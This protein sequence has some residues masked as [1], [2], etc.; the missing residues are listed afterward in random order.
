MEGEPVELLR[1]EV[2][3]SD[4]RIDEDSKKARTTS[5]RRNRKR[6]DYEP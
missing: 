3:V 1:C 2:A 4:E 5:R 6:R